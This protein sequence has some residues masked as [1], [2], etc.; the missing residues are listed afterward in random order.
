MKT[1]KFSLAL[2]V[3]LLILCSSLVPG[4]YATWA[5][6]T[7]AEPKIETIGST[8][9]EFQY[10]DI[11]IIEMDILED[12]SNY[13]STTIKKNSATTIGGGITLNASASSSMTLRLKFY[14]STS[15]TYTYYGTTNSTYDNT[16]ITYRVVGGKNFVD[17]ENTLILDV[18]FSYAN[19]TVSYN[20]TLNAVINFLFQKVEKIS[21][22]VPEG[23]SADNPA[24]LYDGSTNYNGND[25][26]DRWTNWTSTTSGRGEPATLNVVWE[27]E[28]TFDSVKLFHFVDANRNANWYGSCDLPESVSIYYYDETT[29][30]YLLLTEYTESKN[31]SNAKRRTSDGVYQMTIGG[32]TVTFIYTYKGTP[33]IT[34]YTLDNKVTTRAIKVVVDAKPNFFVGLMELQVLNG[35]TNVMT[36]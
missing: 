7:E 23:N 29:E 9:G 24:S 36:A 26:S 13:A 12:S 6:F 8:L 21:L 14:N 2:A 34:T 18:V 11:Y 32:S 3:L 17:G 1:R 10:G 31:Y 30:D 33:P 25:T 27:D 35:T 28:V 20:K 5:Y 15:V 16:G 4:V 22:T 19:S